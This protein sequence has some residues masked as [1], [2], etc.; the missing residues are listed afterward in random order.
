M[1]LGVGGA[2]PP[3]MPG[4]HNRFY[5]QVDILAPVRYV[6]LSGASENTQQEPW[7]RVEVE[8]DGYGRL[9]I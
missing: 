9:W 2:K 7:W 1:A 3:A 5:G 4:Q 6:Y 8:M